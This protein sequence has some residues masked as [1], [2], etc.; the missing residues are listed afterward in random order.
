MQPPSPAR[1][2]VVGVDGSPSATAAL[3]WALDE[4]RSRPARLWL[5][6][7]L[8]QAH[9]DAFTRANPVFAAEERRAAEELL[10]TAVARAR[11]VA[12][13]LDVRAVLQVGT[14]PAVL[15]SEA[16]FA[17]LVVVGSRGRGGF[18]GLLL[19]STSLKVAMKAPCP[20][21]VVRPPT[22]PGRAG[23]S[24]GR[25][26]VGVD[27]SPCCEPALRFAFARAQRRGL[28]LTAVRVWRSPAVYVDVPS[29][30]MWLQLERKERAA[31]AEH[32][33]S[34]RERYPEVDVMERT[35]LGN[36]AATLVDES[37]GAE[38]LVLGGHGRGGVGALLLGSV[39][40]AALHHARCPVVVVQR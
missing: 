31:L 3:D 14:P 21:V 24:A 39:S 8:N 40:H 23:S 34:W 38:L 16:R 1:P 19:G 5:V 12:S 32:L 2:V 15:V 28:G 33:T 13:G 35:V 26:V 17:E 20:V 25:I 36:A 22:D 27:G 4:A 7:A 10:E 9:S 11:A 6:H 29:S 18:A 37:A 30:G